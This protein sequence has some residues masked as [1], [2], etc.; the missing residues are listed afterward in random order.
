MTQVKCIE[1]KCLGL[2]MTQSRLMPDPRPTKEKTSE[3]RSSPGFEQIVNNYYYQQHSAIFLTLVK[4]QRV[5]YIF[6]YLFGKQNGACNL[7]HGEVILKG[8]N[9]KQTEF[10]AVQEY[11]L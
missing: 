8:L 11:L 4:L 5:I 3:H 9:R 6:F 10:I 1:R 2:L 7:L